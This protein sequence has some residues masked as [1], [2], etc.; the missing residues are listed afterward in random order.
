MRRH[1]AYANVTATVALFLAV[2]TGGA[3]AAKTLIASKDIKNNSITGTDIKDASIGPKDLSAASKVS[4]PTG[5]K[6]DTGPAGAAGTPGENGALNFKVPNSKINAGVTTL[7]FGNVAKSACTTVA[8]TSLTFSSGNNNITDDV[9]TASPR[10][11]LPTG[12]TYSAQ[13]TGTNQ[14]SVTVCN[15]GGLVNQPVGSLTFNWSAIDIS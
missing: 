1:L 4:G 8:S 10:T 14:I 13:G 5:A 3:Y 11:A 9:V 6:G 12:V 15:V 7:E 2:S